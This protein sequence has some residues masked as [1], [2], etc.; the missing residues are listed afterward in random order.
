M[1]YRLATIHSMC[2]KNSA[3]LIGLFMGG[4]LLLL[5]VVILCTG[6]MVGLP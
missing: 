4:I 5:S 3:E 6:V 2:E 1:I